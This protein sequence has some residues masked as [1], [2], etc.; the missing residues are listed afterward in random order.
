MV[1]LTISSDLREEERDLLEAAGFENDRDLLSATAEA[2]HREMVKAN[3]VLDLIDE[4]P[5]VETVE[6]WLRKTR[7]EEQPKAA[8][9]KSKRKRAKKGAKKAARKAVQRTTEEPATTKEPET[10]AQAPAAEDAPAGEPV[11][12]NYEADPDVQDMLAKSPVALP[13]PNRLLVEAKIPPSEIAIAPVLNRAESD[14]EVNV[15]VVQKKLDTIGKPIR[16]ASGL[17]E[18]TDFRAGKK[19]EFDA[20]RVRHI[21]DAASDPPPEPSKEPVDERVRLLRTAREK[22]NRG[23][24]PNSVWF[25][26]GVLH[27]R[28]FQV[29]FGC[30]ILILF[31][32]SVPLAVIAAPLLMLSDNEAGSF[33]WVPK[34]FLAFPI[35]VPVLGLLYFAISARVKCRV[36]GQ[37]VLVPKHCRKNVKAHH[38]PGLGHI[39]PLAL[40]TL[41]FR[42]FRCT[43]CGT[44]VRIKE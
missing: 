33:T 21:E 44:S 16:R 32:I 25:I 29:A 37:K 28:P 17:V 38:I 42:W 30:I 40:H 22:T 14:L 5:A 9:K 20:S 7:G 10:P 27:D 4:A 23:K 13:L 6:G 41:T 26:R 34:W 31:Q 8:K 43:F 15:T 12:V 24:D 2:I 18:V 3:E 1:K 36:C 19:R 39:L 11:L 35:A